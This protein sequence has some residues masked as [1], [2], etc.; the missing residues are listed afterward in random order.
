MPC[1]P[2]QRQSRREMVEMLRS[3]FLIIHFMEMK[4]ISI[5]GLKS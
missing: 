1:P 2:H 5:T 3:K 4:E